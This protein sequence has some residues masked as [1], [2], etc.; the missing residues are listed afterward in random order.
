VAC[1]FLLCLSIYSFPH[2][3]K[4]ISFFVTPWGHA[5]AV[6]NFKEKGVC[7]GLRWFELRTSVIIFFKDLFYVYEYTL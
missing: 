4:K 3:K 2:S 1:L 6:V 7:Q 5:T